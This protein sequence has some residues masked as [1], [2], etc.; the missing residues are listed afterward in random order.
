MVASIGTETATP[1]ARPAAA[2]EANGGG[3]PTQVDTVVI[4]AGSGGL[5]VAVGLAARGKRVALVEAAQ[6]GGDC[7]NVGCIPSKT[8]IHR[9]RTDGSQDPVAALAHVRR[10]RDELRDRET[11]EFGSLPNVD[12]VA[13]RARLLPP[14]R[15]ARRTCRRAVA[16]TTPD[17]A[18]HIIRSEHVVVATGARP[19]V[20]D[21]PGLPAARLLTNE[22][23]FD[24]ADAPGH[25]VVVG[26]GGI[27]M[28]LAFAFRR[29]GSRVTVVTVA[30]RVMERSLPDVG[31]ALARS[32]ARHGIALHV[33]TRVDS[34]DET[35]RTLRVVDR[36]GSR[37][38]LEQVDNVLMAVGRQRATDHLDLE[39]VGVVLDPDG[40]V[41]TDG[42]GRTRV[43]GLWA[44]GDVTRTAAHTHSANAQGRRVVQRIA[45]GWL[46][47]RSPEP[48]YPT[49]TFSEPEV[50]TAGTM[51]ERLRCHPDLITRIR[52]DL[53]TRTDRGY[54]D[55]TPE[56]FVVVDAIRLTGT[57]VGAT[58]VGPRA[59]EM[60]PLFALAVQERISL[61]RLF[62]LVQPYPTFSSGVQKVADGFVADTLGNLPREIGGYL[63]HRWARR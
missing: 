5:T 15:R 48:A 58:I 22:T 32:L 50:A 53:A 29:L 42:Y 12:L 47:A 41:P 10:K 36:S 44:V 33:G 51:R 38:D 2:P 24:L 45:L 7:T 21:V 11:R 19:R 54:T 35:T 25:L 59:S 3:V 23:V 14:S 16:V 6:V 61:F 13:G 26:G 9:A 55:D 31:E 43:A 39:A 52:V 27:G 4:G 63:R 57:V 8:L 18:E 46:P 37:T 34:H 60:V 62:R 28:E 56:A 20:L 1:R 49:A 40:A 30:D 17:G